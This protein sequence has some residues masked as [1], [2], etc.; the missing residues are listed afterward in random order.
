MFIDSVKTLLAKNGGIQLV[1]SR[2]EQLI[3]KQEA[4][5]LNVEDNEVE[6][7]IRQACDLVIIILTGGE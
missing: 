4:G 7:I 2:L 5:E 1:C 6:A 3:H